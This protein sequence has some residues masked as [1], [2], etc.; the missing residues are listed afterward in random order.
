[1]VTFNAV[2]DFENPVD[3]GGNDVYNIVV[4]VPILTGSSTARATPSASPTI[5][6]TI[7]AVAVWF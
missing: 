4:S 7:P 6:R 2:S 5:S 1:V 3:A